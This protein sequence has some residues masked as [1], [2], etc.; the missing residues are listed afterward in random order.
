VLPAASQHAIGDSL[1]PATA[2]H[3]R[4]PPLWL[5]AVLA[6][7]VLLAAVLAGNALGGGGTT[8]K[9]HVGAPTARPSTTRAAVRT[10]QVTSALVGM[11]VTEATGRLR[12]I[13]MVPKVAFADAGKDVT[14]GSVVDV[15][16]Q[17][18]LPVGT[19][20]TLTVAAGKGKGRDKG[21]GD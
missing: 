9:K 2:A 10:A 8:K 7:L 12:A 4:R 17:G 16:P 21:E 19:V 5:W 14:P 18:Q 15:K 1:P 6:L 11:S 20:V 13:N 3:R